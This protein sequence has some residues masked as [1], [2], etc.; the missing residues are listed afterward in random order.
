MIK[1]LGKK[2]HLII[3][4]RKNNYLC[5]HYDIDDLQEL[6]GNKLKL[7]YI[8]YDI[9]LHTQIKNKIKL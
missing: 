2:I 1:I 6:D 4:L 7:T 9:T 8:L 3:D 5:N